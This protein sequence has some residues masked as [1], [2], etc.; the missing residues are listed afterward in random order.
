MPTPTEPIP[1]PQP[2]DYDEVIGDLEPEGYGAAFTE[3]RPI[4]AGLRA[5]VG[6]PTSAPPP[7]AP[8]ARP[9]AVALSVR[10]EADTVRRLRALAAVKGTKYQTLLKAFVQE[11]LYEEE[12]REG[13]VGER[14]PSARRR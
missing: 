11:R 12:R 7:P 14:T 8:G 5:L 9:A 4:P 3:A 13:L 2:G 10:L 1:E 6:P